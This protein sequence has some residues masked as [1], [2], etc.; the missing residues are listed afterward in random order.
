PQRRAVLVDQH[1]PAP[2]RGHG[3]GGDP[4]GGPGLV[5][6]RPGGGDDRLPPVE[7]ILLGAAAIEQR[8]PGRSGLPA[9]HLGVEG[10]DRDLGS[11]GAEVDGQH[12]VLHR[13]IA[14]Q[15]TSKI[16]T[17]PVTSPITSCWPT[18]V[19]VVSGKLG[20]RQASARPSANDHSRRVR[21]VPTEASTR[22][23]ARKARARTGPTWPSSL[24][25]FWPAPSEKI[26]MIPASPAVTKRLLVESTA[27]AYGLELALASSS[28]GRPTSRSQTLM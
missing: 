8:E 22:S 5:E 14:L 24:A 13:S 3:H 1:G 26:S 20:R 9:E 25:S 19:T 28:S 4:L 16:S 6:H 7:R 2:L 11:R 23:S 12:A 18:K 10:H 15:S 17:L 27:S 21:S